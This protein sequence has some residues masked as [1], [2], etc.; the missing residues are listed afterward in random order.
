M[1]SFIDSINNTKHGNEVFLVI[2]DTGK[3]KIDPS[4]LTKLKIECHYEWI[5]QEE[6]IPYAEVMRLKVETSNKFCNESTIYWN[7]DDDYVFNPYWYIV[8]KTIFNENKEVDYLS[9]LKV[10]RTIEEMPDFYSGFSLIRAY[11]CMGGAFGTRCRKFY[12]VIQAYFKEHGTL[13]MFDQ[14]FWMF[15][16]GLRGR[17]DQIYIIQDFSLIQQCNLISS[18]LDQKGSRLEHQYGIDFEP[19]GNPFNIVG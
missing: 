4:L 1:V 9:L 14:D 3:E 6:R 5:P 10:N 8:A 7:S 12:P 19:V 16:G 11:S 13:N 18:Y 15:L 2:V 17:Q